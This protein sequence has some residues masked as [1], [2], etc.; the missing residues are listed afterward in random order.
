MR[1]RKIERDDCLKGFPM[2]R[3]CFVYLYLYFFR[4]SFKHNYLRFSSSF[5]YCF[6][7]PNASFSNLLI[8]LS[9]HSH[10]SLFYFAFRSTILSLLVIPFSSLHPTSQPFTL[11]IPSPQYCIYTCTVSPHPSIHRVHRV[12]AL[13]AF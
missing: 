2:Q 7:I 6:L 8:L 11:P 9:F 4:I 3:F 12:L 10:I 13:S 5:L 1:G